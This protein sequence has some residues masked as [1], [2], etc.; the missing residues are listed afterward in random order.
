VLT[1]AG[2]KEVRGGAFGLV[3]LEEVEEEEAEEDPEE[4]AVGFLFFMFKSKMTVVKF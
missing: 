4:E 2:I 1:A 3:L